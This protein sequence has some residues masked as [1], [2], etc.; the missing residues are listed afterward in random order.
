MTLPD[1]RR[2]A[3]FRCPVPGPDCT[4]PGQHGSETVIVTTAGREQW[5]VGRFDQDFRPSS[6]LQKASAIRHS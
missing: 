2:H 5:A 1:G 6:S 3:R 4:C